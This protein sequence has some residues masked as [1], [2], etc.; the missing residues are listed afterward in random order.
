M[1][2]TMNSVSRT[3]SKATLLQAL[4]IHG[5]MPRSRLAQV[6]GL[7]RATISVAVAQMIQS[8][9]VVETDDRQV[10]GGRPAV[11]VELAAGT[12]AI[13]GADLDDQN[14][15]IAAF[16][17]LGHTLKMSQISAHDQSAEAAVEALT[18]VLPQ[19]MQ[20]IDVSIVPLLGLG[21][22]GLV[23]SKNGVIRVAADVGWSDIAMSEAVGRVTGWPVVILNRHRARGLAEC[24]FGAA[25][26][27]KEVVY[28]GVGTG[29]A[30]GVFVQGQLVPGALGGAGEVGHTTLD[31][32][33]PLCSCGN[34][35]C[36]QVMAAGPALLQEARWRIRVGE[37]S[38][39]VPGPGF[40]VQLLRAVDVCRE[41][42]EGDPLAIAVVEEA[43]SYLG[44][45]LSNLVNILNPEVIVLGGSIPRNSRHYVAAATRTM[46]Q[47]ALGSL[48]AATEV[49]IAQLPEIGGALGAANYV[50]DQHVATCLTADTWQ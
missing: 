45:A 12:R 24:R 3:G 44:V 18:Q 42:E 19:F 29:I 37:R 33:G 49:A 26:Y 7:S 2:Q 21:V 1:S 39:L 31:M 8:G 11:N 10:T 15:T 17:L 43:G 20:E 25:K 34:R 35:G 28:V 30:A 27:H 40:D 13:I 32:D 38:S 5:A 46:R 22:P 50:L 48:A 23:D 36:L 9:L 6:T 14:W 47:R 41:A 4:R 16:D